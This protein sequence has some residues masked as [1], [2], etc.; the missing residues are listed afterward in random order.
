MQLRSSNEE[1]QKMASQ[2]A[3]MPPRPAQS[4][5][6]QGEL[7]LIVERQIETD[8]V[9]MGVLR[10]GTPFLNQRG[11]ARLCGVKNK[12]IGL[13]SSEWS[14][15]TRSDRTLRIQQMLIER[16]DV[17]EVAARET[18]FGRQKVLAYPD[19]VCMAI[20]EYYAFEADL[21]GKDLALNSYRKL[22]SHGLRQFI[23]S[24]V[25]YVSDE[26]KDLWRVFK[27]RV[28]LTYD[29]VP[30][31]YFGIFKELSDLIVTLGL[32]GLHIDENFVPDI[33]VGQAW[34][35]HWS[36]RR[37][38]DSYGDRGTYQHHYPPY[39]PQA[40]SNP[41]LAAC[42]PE[43]ALGEFRRWFR[44]DYIG[45]GRFRAYLTRKAHELLLPHGYVERA[46]L[47]LTKSR[48]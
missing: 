43:E 20:L 4:H 38:F 26:T 35:K 36:E 22:A 39:F 32:Q 6:G 5:S 16:G 17:V 37:L 25:G 19:N 29:A 31:G 33:S 45:Q 30:V 1:A 11:L 41:Q 40:A 23:Y 42:Y 15:P 27:D 2:V 18:Y 14:S 24:Q 48:G 21:S 13:I 3:K 8:G 9:G 34:A 10:D 44:Q 46:M 28:S 7:G 47:A 12:Y